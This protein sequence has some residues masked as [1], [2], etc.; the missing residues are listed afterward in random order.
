MLL[1]F[2]FFLGCRSSAV[3]KQAKKATEKK[4]VKTKTSTV[5]HSLKMRATKK[6][7]NQKKIIIQFWK[8]KIKGSNKKKERKKYTFALPSFSNF[9]RKKSDQ[10]FLKEEKKR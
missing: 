9:Y 5:I 4:Q 1:L 3:N 8:L 10:S 7:N 6:S 2:H